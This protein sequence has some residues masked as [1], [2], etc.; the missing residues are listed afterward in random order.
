MGGDPDG[1][2]RITL[3][4]LG[5]LADRL[6]TRPVLVAVPA[7]VSV[8]GQL[9]LQGHGLAAGAV[10]VTL[11]GWTLGVL[12]ATDRELVLSVDTGVPQGSRKLE[13]KVGGINLP[14]A[15]LTVR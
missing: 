15:I 9:T 12:S 1:D 8:P 10:E 5:L 4:D 2:G 11:G 13:L 3:G 7:E 14:S 6:L